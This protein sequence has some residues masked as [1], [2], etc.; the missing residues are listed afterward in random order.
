MNLEYTSQY[1]A[2]RDETVNSNSKHLA[3]GRH[4]VV[5]G[6]DPGGRPLPP[7]YLNPLGDNEAVGHIRPR[8]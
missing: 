3:L 5:S 4:Q 8:H 1:V 7:D 6:M 2:G